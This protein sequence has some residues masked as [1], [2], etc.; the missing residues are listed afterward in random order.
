[1][2]VYVSKTGVEWMILH[3]LYQLLYIQYKEFS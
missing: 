1:M 3:T 2:C